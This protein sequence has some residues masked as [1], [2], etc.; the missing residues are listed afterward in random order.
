MDDLIKNGILKEKKV[1]KNINSEKNKK[2]SAIDSIL[3]L[4]SQSIILF[5][6]FMISIG[7]GYS[8]KMGKSFLFLLIFFFIGVFEFFI[9]R[10]LAKK[11]SIFSVFL[12]IFCIFN[13]IQIV[14]ILWLL[15]KAYL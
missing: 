4:I 11:K 6:V 2:I 15:I 5:F 8:G 3:I 13:T 14:G 7:I 9:I 10:F 1:E 12:G